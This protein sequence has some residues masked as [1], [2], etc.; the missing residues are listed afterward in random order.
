MPKNSMSIPIAMAKAIAVTAPVAINVL[1]KHVCLPVEHLLLADCSATP[2]TTTTQ[3]N[4]SHGMG[5]PA[6]ERVDQ[7]NAAE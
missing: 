3:R 4:V 5:L 6:Q 1:G 7:S 2:A